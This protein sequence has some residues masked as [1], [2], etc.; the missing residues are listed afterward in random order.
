MTVEQKSMDNQFEQTLGAAAGRVGVVSALLVLLA[1]CG[2]RGDEP[3]PPPPPAVDVATVTSQPVT[4]WETFTGRLVA[5]HTVELRPRVSGYIDEVA[6]EE[7]A[8]VK[9]GDPLFRIDPRP[10][11]A[12]EQAASAELALARS[13][14]EQAQSEAQRAERLLASRAI[15]REEYDQ[16]RTALSGARARVDAARA[17][18]EDAR[19]DLGYTTVES[20]VDGRVGRALVTRGNL[21]SADQ[22]LLTTV[23]SVDPM[24]VYFEPDEQTARASQSLLADGK[25]LPVR[26]A[27]AGEEGFPRQGELDFVDNHLNAGTGTLMYRAV[28]TNQD[29]RLRPGQFARVQMPVRRL[30]SALLVDRKA[31]VTNQ[32]RRLV[33]VVNGENK[34]D[35]RQV[36]L[37][38]EVGELRV[39]ET[40]LSPG[41]RVIVSG[42][43][44]VFGPGMPVDPN[45]VAA[46]R[47]EFPGETVAATG[48]P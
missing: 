37:G 14:L 13:Q 18:L 36:T 46:G 2:A 3:R 39:V 6:F 9:A 31:L 33:Y 48:N 1:G 43:L 40:G 28:V 8:L 47:M 10:Y 16:R 17:A 21:A 22:T 20:P 29:G 44:K 24:Y 35:P 42:Q 12:R 5:P 7:G 32:D 25:S 34:V 15:S 38:P 41:E 11:E 19:L 30:D 26:V 23:V 4:V 45:P 27:L